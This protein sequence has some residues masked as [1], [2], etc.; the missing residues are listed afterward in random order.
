MRISEEANDCGTIVSQNRSCRA[1]NAAAGGQEM[2][3]CPLFRD[4]DIN[5]GALWIIDSGGLAGESQTGKPRSR[6]F[7]CA[8]KVKNRAWQTLRGRSSG[9]LV[10]D[11]AANVRPEFLHDDRNRVIADLCPPDAGRIRNISISFRMVT[12]GGNSC[13]ERAA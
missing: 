10:T 7:L 5:S 6:T 9:L 12:I 11:L 1:R 13:R 2:E 8:E 4:C 3:L